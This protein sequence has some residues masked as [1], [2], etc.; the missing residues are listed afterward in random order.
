MS[1][2]ASLYS[3][4]F[5][6]ASLSLAAD[7]RADEHPLQIPPPIHQ[8][9]QS[10]CLDCHSGDDSEA[11]LR[12]DQLHNLELPS[13]LE[14]LA[15]METQLFFS[16]M[17]PADAFSMPPGDRA[18]LLTW[19][20]GELSSHDASELQRKR[21]QPGYGNYVSHEALFDAV[22]SSQPASTP[23]RRWLVSPQ[24]FHA[25]VMDIFHLSGPDWDSLKGRS[26][27]GV[28]NPFLLPEH[29]GVRY[30]DD[31]ILNGGHLL[32]MLG[33]ARWIASR[34]ITIA[35][36]LGKD[37]RAISFPDPRDRW[38]PRSFPERWTIFQEVLNTD[39]PDQHQL[40]KAIREQ[41]QSVLRRDPVSEE[42]QRY[43]GLM[44]SAIEA[45]GTLEGMRQ[46]LSAVV[47]ESE[48]LYREEF[49]AGPADE[50]GRKVLAPHEAAAAIAWSLG[51]RGP[52]S[53]LLEAADQGLLLTQQDYE[54]EVRRLLADQYYFRGQIDPAL[55]GKHYRSNETSHPRIVRFFREFFGYP[56]ALK[57]FKDTQ[58]SEGK[59]QNPGRGTNGTPGWLVLEADRFVTRHVEQDQRVFENLLTSN[60]F[61]VYHDKD[62]A[63]G[64]KIVEDWR[65]VWIKLRDSDWKNNPQQ[66][67]DQNLEFL[68]QISS[69]RI[70]DNSR[71][72][73]LVNF[74]H[75]FEESFGQGRTPFTTVPWA[76]G[77]T[78]HHSP[79]Y[80][81]PPTPSIY[82]YGSWK[83]SKYNDNLEPRVFWDY[84]PEQP[85]PVPNRKG[86]L[87][88]P[89]WLIAHSGNFQTDPVR[90]GLWIRKK[91][92]A[93]IVP[94]I[95]ITVDAQIPDDH[96]RTLRDR[97][98]DVTSAQS[99]NRCHTRMNPLGVAFE[100]YDDFGRFRT[101]E[102][103]EHE[104]HR[105]RSGNGKS[106]FDEYQ[107]LPVVTTGVLTG[108]G[109]PELD[110]PVDNALELIDRI[111]RA[112]RTRQSIIR[113]A[114]RFYL[115]R[116]EELSDAST[117]IA[118]DQAYIQS[119][120]SFQEVI[121]ALL[122]SDSFR[123]RRSV[124][125]TGLAA[126]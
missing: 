19:C 80:S 121:V 66:V 18:T 91:L 112:D 96:D 9:L 20:S 107:T 33:N 93:G 27:A 41:F 102:P 13:Q 117:L 79:F 111:A 123:L 126:Q 116:N 42:T 43:L 51:D 53:K 47:L 22:H 62:N 5:L 31:G 122:T 81:L 35:A 63:A 6:L 40:T 32:V 65:E 124:A 26:F 82:R 98:V 3:G 94:D 100:M 106:T 28:S 68:S 58:R 105:L 54:R 72:G 120:G 56:A 71:P 95:P 36:N 52:D 23:G 16:M 49:G 39:A 24:I 90:R 77:Y 1:M 25:R 118:A 8:L 74:M 14:I 73:E 75:Y 70:K 103:L 110:G 46:M 37:R 45:G 61:F 17:P 89:A 85:F 4:V 34:Q 113:H 114:F 99:C 69:I 38:L 84:P 21:R 59:Y 119:G 64:R 12:L 104:E 101:H 87:T 44:Q 78:F 2:P 83:S 108:S 11:G 7:N 86:I 97:L 15:A 29:S 48:F 92:L 55:N 109:N 115:G 30:F 10:N 67:L 88:H 50:H 125:P 60:E 76:H 57:V